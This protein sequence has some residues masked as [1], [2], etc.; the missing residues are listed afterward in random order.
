[1]DNPAHGPV[2]VVHCEGTDP[3]TCR[4]DAVEAALAAEPA[5]R[6][7]ALVAAGTATDRVAVFAEV[8]LAAVE[9]G[10]G[11]AAGVV[12]V[13]D[14]LKAVTDELFS[15]DGRNV[16]IGDSTATATVVT[17]SVDRAAYRRLVA[18]LLV[19]RRVLEALVDAAPEGGQHL[20]R[21]VPR[22]LE[23]AGPAHPIAT[24]AH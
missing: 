11:W 2:A 4:R 20:L 13:T 16:G 9:A 18:P 21:P 8:A 14:A 7:V 10:A 23:L 24:A 19:P 22:L 3:V 1:M 17:A 15:P 12:P 5:A 6:W